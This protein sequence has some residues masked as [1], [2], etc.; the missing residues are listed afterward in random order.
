MITGKNSRYKFYW[1]GNDAGTGGVG[2]L[3]SEKWIEKVFEVKRYSDRVML[4]KIIIGESVV[5]FLSVYAP[6]SGLAESE[7]E[8]FYDLVQ[9]VV[10]GLP[11][12]EMLFPCGDWNGHIGNSANGFEGAHGGFGYGDR[13]VDGERL[14]EFAVANNLAIGNSFFCKRDSHLITYESGS[15][16]SMIDFILLRRRDLKLVTDVKVIPSE[17]IVPQHK[18]LVCDLKL[19]KPII[20]PKIFTPKLKTWKLRESDTIESFQKKFEENLVSDSTEVY[21]VESTWSK[22]KNTL[23]DTSKEVCGYTKKHHIKR[24]TWWWNEEV[25]NVITEKRRCWKAWKLGGSK[26]PYLAAKRASKRGVFAA[27]K[28]A[29]ELRFSNLKPGDNSVFRLARQMRQVNQDIIG[30]K[31]VKDDSGNL[32]TTDEAKK[33]AWK[34]H[35]ERLSNVEFPWDPDHLTHTDPVLGAAPLIT[36]EMVSKAVAKMKPGKAAGPS[37]IIAEM[38]KAGNEQCFQLLADLANCII[39]ENKIPEDWEESFLISLYKGKGDAL[40]R[41][42]YRGLKLL[43]QTL[44]VVERII[45]NFIR[46]QVSIDDMQFGFMPGRGTTDAIFI[47]RQMQEKYLAKKLPLYFAFVDLEKA[48]DRVPHDVIW[49]AMRKLGVDEWIIKVVQAMY[50]NPRSSVRVG[51]SYSKSF[52]IKV[53]VHQGSV[54][55]PLLFIIV[56]EALSLEFKVGCPWELLYADDLAIIA[57]TLEELLERLQKWKE[58]MESKGLRVNMPKTK[59]MFCKDGTNTLKDSG[60]FPCGVCRSGVG[61]NSIF[62]NSCAH[63]THKNC[64]GIVG[65]LKPDPSFVCPRCCGLARPID[66]RTVTEVL[67]N[68]E[69]LDVVDCFCY[70]GDSVSPGGGCQVAVTTRIRC[71]WGKFRELLPL[72]TSRSMK[73]ST[74]GRMYNLYVR[75]AMSHASECWALTS[76]DLTRL[77]RSDR[78]MIRW[79][80]NVRWTDRRSSESLLEQL[81]IPSLSTL[82]RCNRL[83]WYGHVQRNDGC[84]NDAL[85]MQIDGEKTR[86]R[87]KK[88]WLQSVKQDCRAWNMPKDATDRLQWRSTMKNCMQDCNPQ[89][90][91]KE[92]V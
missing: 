45:E 10:S 1:S 58:S 47:L 73:S 90:G 40:E 39:S 83:R 13:N 28:A 80:C 84:I 15:N 18:L 52:G 44:K 65:K 31:C 57:S 68:G 92:A 38:L 30:D 63:W 79:M 2:L 8:K 85:Y 78:S 61:N 81:K 35:Y 12:S 4:I 14:L 77:Q 6:Q 64:S 11:E 3:L 23:L 34:Q 5:S 48:F 36:S 16:K 76:A 29:E 24:E 43:E 9:E 42:N 62:C 86:G 69:K 50:K 21:D 49:W 71:A 41:G 55:S 67:L 74:K 75:K 54:L 20:V 37:G 33:V 82:L 46:D 70:L 72:L 89:L 25:E 56:L 87:P 22:L 59:I 17:E 26:E 91:G 88:T 27:K 66:C 19:T 7:K 53:G 60:K 32:S 51:N